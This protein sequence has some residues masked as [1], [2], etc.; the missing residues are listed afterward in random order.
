VRELSHEGK[1]KLVRA[2]PAIILAEAGKLWLPTTGDWIRSYIDELVRFTGRDDR[3]DDQV[4]ITAY[5]VWQMQGSRFDPSTH[6]RQ[7]HSE[8][9]PGHESSAE[10]NNLWGR[11]LSYS[12]LAP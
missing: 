12:R 10:T 9:R 1:G 6:I 4:D 11:G 2:T 7:E 8:I 5:A 3:E